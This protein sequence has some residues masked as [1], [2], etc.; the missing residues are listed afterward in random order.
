MDNDHDKL[1]RLYQGYAAGRRPQSR[2]ACPSPTEMAESFEP[3][4]SRRRKKK[5]IDHITDCPSCREEF[6]LLLGGQRWDAGPVPSAGT[7]HDTEAAART[8]LRKGRARVPLWRLAGAVAG[9][10]LIIASLVAVRHQWE[11]SMALR[12]A[13]PGIALLAPRTGQSV[14]RPV[15]F[16]WKSRAPAESYVLELFDEALLPVWTSDKLSASAIQIPPEI[17]SRLSPGKT[18]YWMV[19]GFSGRDKAGESPMGRFSVR[20]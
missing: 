3:S 6:L 15:T 19:T 17:G 20:R 10:G 8:D 16:R 9:L 1:R 13:Q 2:R 4:A 11:L 7:V 14:S 18:Y 5:I 12:S